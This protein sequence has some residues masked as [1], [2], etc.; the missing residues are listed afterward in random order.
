LFLVERL[1][2]AY[3]MALISLS[4]PSWRWQCAYRAIVSAY[5]DELVGCGKGPQPPGNAIPDVRMMFEFVP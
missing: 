2:T 5:F 4:L 3:L 1:P